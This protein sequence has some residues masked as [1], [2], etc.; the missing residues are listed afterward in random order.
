M[1]YSNSSLVAVTHLS[2]NNSGLRTHA[3]DRISPHCTVGQT[4]AEFLGNWFDNP[5]LE[6]SCNYAIDKDGRILLC[7][8]ESD[9]SW[10]TSSKA[11]DQRAV[12]IECASDKEPPYAFNATV[13]AR[14]IEL[15]VDICARNGKTKLIWIAD[16]NTALAY[17]P[18]ADEMLLTVH[19]W[20][21]SKSCPGDWLMER[22][23]QLAEAV[24][25]NLAGNAAKEDED[26]IYRVQV[27]AYKRRGNAENM[28]KKLKD[29]GFS[30]F[31][32]ENTAI[33]Q[34]AAETPQQ[35]YT[36]KITASALN[37]RKAPSESSDIVTQVKKDSIFTIVD[38]QD[39]WGK[40]KSGI[41]WISLAYTQK[42]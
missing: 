33:K 22:M 40:L 6:A 27:G 8:N 4:T 35:T 30:G 17:E 9:R 21:S 1:T 29:A 38:E 31:I 24:T 41:G 11:N 14:L 23:S 19:R 16:K 42:L 37:V 13:Y 5:N 12:T 26:K 36:V 7:V 32:V 2:P 10:C 3:I 28:L 34:E 39:G 25:Y 15:C 18:K 20:F